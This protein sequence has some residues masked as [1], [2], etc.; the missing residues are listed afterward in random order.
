M[1]SDTSLTFSVLARDKASRVLGAIAG[2]FRSTAAAAEE[3]LSE[4]SDDTAK[5]DAEIERV[6]KSLRELSAEFART[7]NKELFAKIKRDRALLTNLR[8]I[9]KELDDIG[10]A[11]DR[12]GDRASG[13]FMARFGDKLTGLSG[14]VAD[15]F[16]GL[17]TKVKGAVIAAAT[18]VAG[19]F[20]AALAAGLLL[21]L[22][23]GVI[24]AGIAAA[25]RDPAVAEAWKGLG[26]Q[27]Q[28]SLAGFTNE[29]KG[30]A[31]RAAQ[32]FGDAMQRME[33]TFT[34]IGKNMAP[35][36][37]RLAPALADM[38]ET[39]LPGIE[40]ALNASKPLFD[41]LAE[42]APKIG[43]ALD[44]FFTSLADSGP[45]AVIALDLILSTFEGLIR[46]W[47]N[48]IEFWSKTLV[49]LKEFFTVTIPEAWNWLVER[50][51]TGV[52]KIGQFVGGAKDRI[53]EKFDQVVD[54]VT[55]M[56]GRIRKA[57]SGMWDGVTDAFRSSV[58][59]II[60]RWNGLSFSLPPVTV[61]GIGQ[62]WGGATLHTPDIPYLA[63]GGTAV[64]SGL[65][66][67]GERGPELVSLTR[68][69]QVTPL[70][71][72]GRHGAGPGGEVRVIVVGGDREAVAYFRRMSQQ[73]G[74]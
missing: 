70:R 30:P 19:T 46:F 68:G 48:G 67:V 71:R 29:F 32:T 69:A 36:I 65:A 6:E 37:D 18:L 59:S 50:I 7:G 43:E 44:S 24:A 31:A 52:D 34:R 12:A 56:P 57:A 23:G 42:H 17:P 14:I 16:A 49:A 20:V 35:I 2:G 11:A 28:S 62:I 25:V 4:A 22:G 60:R 45:G 27:A 72:T 53:V 38:A 1:A 41:K 26:D 9:R 58:N 51:K 66:V 3:A 55:G 47:G 54:F 5:L 64:T 8:Q 33:P 39:A 61:P 21:G 74:F 73:Y 15:G 63:K 40:D 13:G 10:D